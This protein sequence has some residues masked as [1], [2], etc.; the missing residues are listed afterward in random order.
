MM[1]GQNPFGNMNT[2]QGGQ[3]QQPNPFMTNPQMAQ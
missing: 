2:M 3:Q 1:G